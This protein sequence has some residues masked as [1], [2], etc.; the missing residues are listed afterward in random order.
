M[1]VYFKFDNLLHACLFC[2]RSLLLGEIRTYEPLCFM[3]VFC[4]ALEGIL[5]LFEYGVM[6]E[7]KLFD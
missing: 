6:F 5:N 3:F 1:H 2:L 4:G 7:L